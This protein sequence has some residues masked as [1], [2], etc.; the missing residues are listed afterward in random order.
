M[1]R[2]TN[3]G[4]TLHPFDSTF[5]ARHT[6]LEK[7][8]ALVHHPRHS[9]HRCP[10]GLASTPS[11]PCSDSTP[12]VKHTNTNDLRRFLRT[13]LASLSTYSTPYLSPHL[14]HATVN[15]LLL[16]LPGA[17]TGLT[18]F[19]PAPS[20]ASWAVLA[21]ELAD[22]PML[23]AVQ[24][25]EPPVVEV[26]EVALGTP[27]VEHVESQREEIDPSAVSGGAAAAVAAAVTAAEIPA[28]APPQAAA[29]NVTKV[30]RISMDGNRSSTHRQENATASFCLPVILRAVLR[31]YRAAEHRGSSFSACPHQ[32][33]R[34][35]C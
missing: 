14:T 27:V 13:P 35:K 16:L 32:R 9:K 15:C 18:L 28:V 2:K 4:I 20:Y 1:K 8:Y 3:A 24:S 5:A 10:S 17:S 6:Y 22:L 31:L 34:I 12:S 33:P 7:R 21:A 26:A 19:I 11:T 29:E 30:S 25:N 23:Q